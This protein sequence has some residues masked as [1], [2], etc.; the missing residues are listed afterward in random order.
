LHDDGT[1]LAFVPQLH[2]VIAW[3]AARDAAMFEGVTTVEPEVLLN[4]DL[5]AEDGTTR[6]RV[7]AAILERTQAGAISYERQHTFAPRFA[8]LRHEQIGRQL[9]DAVAD[10][11]LT[12]RTRQMAMTMAEACEVTEIADIA[13]TVAIDATESLR[14]RVDAAYAVCRLGDSATSARLK[15]LAS[16]QPQDDPDNELRGR[17]LV[18]C[19]PDHMTAAELFAALRQPQRRNFHGSYLS[20]LYGQHIAEQLA[21]DDLHA[22]LDWV[23]VRP[24]D[25]ERQPLLRVASEIISRAFAVGRQDLV[26]RLAP[27]VYRAY[28]DLRCPFCLQSGQGAAA[29]DGPDPVQWT[30]WLS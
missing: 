13:A 8:H 10:R 28:H 3:L 30:G 12:D 17:A 26:E 2:E 24:L 14:L 9:A 15:P 20:F 29:L 11:R 6:Q 25:D 27:M 19:W 5:P 4:A 7:I 23:A 16:L 1:S 22:A 21:V 18:A